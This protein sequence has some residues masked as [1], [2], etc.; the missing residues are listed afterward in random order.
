MYTREGPC[1][2]IDR[3]AVDDGVGRGFSNEIT[4]ERYVCLTT[5]LLET[6]LLKKSCLSGTNASTRTQTRPS[7]HNLQWQREK[8]L[9]TFYYVIFCT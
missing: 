3:V 2:L 8:E 6:I 7:C 5:T 1:R 4:Q 9:S